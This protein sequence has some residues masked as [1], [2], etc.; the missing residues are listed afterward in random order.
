M[1]RS[2]WVAIVAGTLAL[3]APAIVAQDSTAV[4]AD[5]MRSG[6]VDWGDIVGNVVVVL[7][8]P[9]MPRDPVFRASPLLP[10][11]HWAVQAARRSEAL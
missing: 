6:E 11:E 4:T 10:F 9:D 3:S 7:P 5:T 1:S 8:A 2:A